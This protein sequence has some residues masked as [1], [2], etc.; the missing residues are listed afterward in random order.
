MGGVGLWRGRSGDSGASAAPTP[1]TSPSGN[2]SG[3]PSSP[4]RARGGA[5]VAVKAV[6]VGGGAKVMESSGS[7]AYVV[8]PKQGEFAAFSAIC[9]HSGCPVDPPKEGRFNCPCHGSVF[10]AATGEVLNGPA[11]KPLR[12]IDVR[13]QG[14]RVELQ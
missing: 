14:G 6:P 8:Q 4:G 1:S 9:T 11:T 10:D 7:A 3:A 2:P 5:S 13:E 12:R